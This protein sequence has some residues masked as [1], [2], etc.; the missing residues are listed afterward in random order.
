MLLAG[1]AVALSV[2][3]RICDSQFTGSSP[4]PAPP[5][6][7]L[8]QATYTCVHLSP[9]MFGTSQVAVISF[10]QKVTVGPVESNDSLLPGL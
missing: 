10:A 3:H 4:G 7:G 9:C 6:S 8:G 5:C 2:G 1:D